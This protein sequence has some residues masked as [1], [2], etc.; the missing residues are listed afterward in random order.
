MLLM[1]ESAGGHAHLGFSQ[2]PPTEPSNRARRTLQS[3][4]SGPTL[5]S[6]RRAEPSNLRFSIWGYFLGGPL[7]HRRATPQEP[8]VLGLPLKDSLAL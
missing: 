4:G 8:G 1:L 2:N 6:G 3:G 7:A 5:Q